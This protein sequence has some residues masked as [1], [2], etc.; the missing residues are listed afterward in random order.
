MVYL[1]WGIGL[2]LFLII[3]AF[4]HYSLPDREIVQIVGTEVVRID[5]EQEDG[6]IISVDQPRINGERPDGNV[7]VFRNDDTGWGWPPY[8][9]FDSAN[10]QAEAQS[11]AKAVEARWVV[12]R[13]YGW[14][15]PVMTMFPNALSIRPASGPDESLIPWLNIVLIGSLILLVLIIRRIILM[16]FNRHVAPVIDDIDAEIE[17]TSDAISRRYRGVRGWLRRLTGG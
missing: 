15:I 13:H 17:E 8:Y 9:K 10:L 1:R 3:A 14:R 2:I 6:S 4:L 5:V 12:V 11:S 16:M 7:S